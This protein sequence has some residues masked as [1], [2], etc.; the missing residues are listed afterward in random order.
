MIFA[1]L[2]LGASWAQDPVTQGEDP[3]LDAQLFR[4]SIDASTTLW[5]DDSQV[6]TELSGTGRVF[7]GWA[8]DPLVYVDDN[9]DSQELISNLFALDLLGAVSWKGVRLGLDLPVVVRSWGDEAGQSGLGDLGL[10][11]KVRILDHDRFPMGLAVAGGASLPTA[12]TTLAL[13]S[14]G[15]GWSVELIADKPLGP[16]LLAANLGTRGLPE[17]QVENVVWDDQLFARLGVSYAITDA[18]GLS[19]DVGGNLTYGEMTNPAGRPAEALLGGWA[20]LGEDWVLR[21]GIGT[22]LTRGIGA[23]KAR[24]VLAL[25]WEPAEQVLDSDLDGLADTVDGCPTRPEDLD[26]YQDR[27]GCPE[28]TALRVRAVDEG[29]NP[30]TTAELRLS[31]GGIAEGG[32]GQLET[33]LFGGS[34]EVEA[35]AAGF[36]TTTAVVTVP[37]GKPYDAVVTL[38]PAATTGL[39]TVRVKDTDGRAVAARVT[40]GEE[41]VQD[42]SGG[43][44]FAVVEAGDHPIL[45]EAD[46]YH[47]VT[48]RVA[49]QAE[50]ELVVVVVVEPDEPEPPPRVEVK[51]DRIDIHDSIYFETASAVIKV[52]S[53]GLL[54]EIAEILQEH[55]ELVR[56]RIEGHTDSRGGEDYN[57]RLS[58][59][60]AAS[61]RAYL[62]E[63]GV[64]PKR[65]HS[66]GFGET[67]PLDPRE[68]EEA[69]SQNRR[70]DFWIEE[71][72]D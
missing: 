45:V 65:L 3:S 26:E 44:A 12:T 56:I 72:S 58:Q 22:G 64:A 42:T 14:G 29:G 37:D 62:I 51:R 50:D 35:A 70:V 6:A 61:V 16:V 28:P 46:G 38:V 41:P 36:K 39:V 60:R 63:R 71:R 59:D 33:E 10:H 21:G 47:P 11:A 13:G 40:L 23:P 57:L 4:P 24:A 32:T 49:V 67:R 5:T 48:Q 69:W 1:T 34:Y 53:H 66:V 7:L 15:F 17:V 54:D 31:G 18:Q 52:E 30:V 20:R 9:G 68:I 27:D 43:V 8:N 25:A 2:L 55:T 19:L